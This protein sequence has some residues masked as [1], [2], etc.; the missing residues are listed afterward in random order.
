VKEAQ[1]PAWAWLVEPRDAFDLGWKIDH[2]DERL[3]GCVECN[4]WTRNGWLYRHLPEQ[5]LEALRD[6]L[7]R[8]PWGDRKALAR[9]IAARSK[10]RFI[11]INPE[12]RAYKATRFIEIPLERRSG[13][14]FNE[15]ELTRMRG[16]RTAE[17]YR[18]HLIRTY[19]KDK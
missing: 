6:S 12:R 15:E 1:W 7:K 8:R 5:T 14:P 10:P 2:Y 17:E 3:V 16:G 19:L 13:V 4:R 9:E 18:W 11:E